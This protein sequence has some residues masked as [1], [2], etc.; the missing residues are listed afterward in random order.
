[1][2]QLN[3]PYKEVNIKE[4][5]STQKK[6]AVS[7][8]IVSKNLD[9]ISIDDGSGIINA[10][11]ETELPINTYVRV[12][13]FLLNYGDGYEIQAHLIQDLSNINQKLHKKVRAL[14]S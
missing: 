10:I 2:P 14:L 6:I 11:I 1:M 13:G 7:G 4:V 8:F 9:R 3:Q 5:D 12:S